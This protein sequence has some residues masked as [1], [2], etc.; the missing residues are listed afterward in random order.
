MQHGALAPRR[1]RAAAGRQVDQEQVR[2]RAEGHPPGPEEVRA[3]GRR[4]RAGGSGPAHTGGVGWR[5]VATHRS[6]PVRRFSTIWSWGTEPA[7]KKE[8]W[9]PLCPSPTTCCRSGK[10]TGDAHPGSRPTWPP[11]GHKASGRLFSHFSSPVGRISSSQVV[12]KVTPCAFLADGG[13]GTRHRCENSWGFAPAG[14][15]GRAAGP[16]ATCLPVS[17]RSKGCLLG[18][19]AGP[20]LGP[21]PHPVPRLPTATWTSS[22]RPFLKG[23][24]CSSRTLG[25]PWTLCWTRC[26]AGTPLKRESEFPVPPSQFS[27]REPRDHAPWRLWPL[28][29]EEVRGTAPPSW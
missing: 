3:G 19:P 5:G 29:R 27:L 16:S 17:S 12:T 28:R 6:W 22:S 8:P 4:R 23:T 10:G 18:R 1:G 11:A 25:K 26:S 14:L 21:C 24:S 20:S 2:R 7:G 15:Q 13:P 9:A